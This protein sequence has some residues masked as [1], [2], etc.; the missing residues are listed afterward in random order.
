MKRV[1]CILFMVM[2]LNI[3]L[4]MSQSKERSQ[5]WT[6]ILTT[7]DP[8]QRLQKLEDFQKKYG[9][10]NDRYTY[11]M[12]LNMTKASFQ[13]KQYD[14]AILMGEKSM[15]FKDVE[16]SDKLDLYLELANSYFV[17]KTDMEKAHKFAN[18]LI[19]LAAQYKDTPQAKQIEMSYVPP[20]LR[21]QAKLLSAGKDIES[22]NKAMDK[23]FQAFNMDKSDTSYQLIRALIKQIYDMGKMDD[24]FTVLERLN[25]LKPNAD[26]SMRLGY[27][28][29]KKGNNDKGIE[30]LKASH[31]L[32]KNARIA[33]DLGISYNKKNEVETAIGYF[34]E[35]F[36]LNDAK[37]SP[38]A[39]KILNHL[40]FNKVAKD[41][42]KEEQEVGF[43][44]ILDAAKAR[45]GITDETQQPPAATPVKEDKNSTR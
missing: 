44:E 22:T 5:D 29:I 12:Y 8:A 6:D 24:A 21:L 41:K 7:M 15:T 13:V 42:T 14:K 38:E 27:D 2:L 31:K 37:L 33:Y 18:E 10:K 11:L 36:V 3:P 9:D 30:F 28:Y 39:E 26:D 4:L 34:A 25:E 40:Y 20:M 19:D 1:I 32:K 23:A 35:C 43:K 16:T 45:L 17:T